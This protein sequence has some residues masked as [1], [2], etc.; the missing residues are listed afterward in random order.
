MKTHRGRV[1]F[2]NT[3]FD[4]VWA[5]LTVYFRFLLFY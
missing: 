2:I 3:L 5:V 4:G 1:R